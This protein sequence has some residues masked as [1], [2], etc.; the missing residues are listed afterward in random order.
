MFGNPVLSAIKQ[1]RSSCS[2]LS[3]FSNTSANRLVTNAAYSLSLENPAPARN[4][5]ALTGV[6]FL[7]WRAWSARNL[8]AMSIVLLLLLPT[9]IHVDAAE[10]AKYLERL[11]LLTHESGG[12]CATKLKKSWS[13]WSAGNSSYNPSDRLTKTLDI[14]QR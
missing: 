1:K 6:L 8:A 5:V 10:R 9:A 2:G 3:L 7:S 14:T 11:F 4:S 12:K 13:D